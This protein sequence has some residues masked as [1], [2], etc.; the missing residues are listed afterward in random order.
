MASSLKLIFVYH[1]INFEDNF[2]NKRFAHVH[3]CSEFREAFFIDVLFDVNSY[4]VTGKEVFLYLSRVQA[5][6]KFSHFQ[7][8]WVECN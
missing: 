6:L 3:R 5:K 8:N 2:Y 4:T 1:I 7:C